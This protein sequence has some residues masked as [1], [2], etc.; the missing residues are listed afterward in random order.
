MNFFPHIK[1]DNFIIIPVNHKTFNDYFYQK[2]LII[3][4][5]AITPYEEAI[6]KEPLKFIRIVC[7]NPKGPLPDFEPW[8]Q[9]ITPRKVLPQPLGCLTITSFIIHLGPIIDYNK[10]DGQQRNFKKI[11]S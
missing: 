5:P 7:D 3:E 9:D 2:I 10:P 8:Y 11:K 6:T 4:V 1:R